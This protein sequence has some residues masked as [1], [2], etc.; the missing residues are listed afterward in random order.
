MLNYHMIIILFI[1]HFVDNVELKSKHVNNDILMIVVLI[2]C[3][4]WVM[5]GVFT[6]FYFYK[7]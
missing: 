2:L 3:W 6:K 4:D 5:I 7:C 1:Q